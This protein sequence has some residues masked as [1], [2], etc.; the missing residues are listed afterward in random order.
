MYDYIL[1]DF[2]IILYD[3]IR[4]LSIQK[5]LTFLT[6]KFGEVASKPS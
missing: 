1:Y 3:F 2:I 6:V 5:I 4:K